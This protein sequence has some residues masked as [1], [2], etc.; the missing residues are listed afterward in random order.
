M[1]R[2]EFF[3]PYQDLNGAQRSGYIDIEVPNYIRQNLTDKFDLRYYQ[4]EAI[5]Y[6]EEYLN[7]NSYSSTPHHL[8][9]Q[10]AT[11]SGKTLIL[12][13]NIL[14]LYK[15]G[16][17]NFIFFVDSKDIIQKTQENLL[18]KSSN[19]YLFNK[20]INI[21]SQDIRVNQVSNF[22][23]I[24]S[25]S[26]NIYLTTVQG[27][28]TQ[29][30]NPSENSLTFE[31]FQNKETVLLA[32][33]AHHL[34][35]ETKSESQ[36]KKSEKEN[37]NR[38]ETTIKKLLHTNENNI[39][40]EYTATANL[41]EPSI[42]DKYEDK[43]LYQ[44]PLRQ[45]RKD[46]Y[47]KEVNVLDADLD[48]MDRALYSAIL[49]QYRLKI[50]EDAGIDSFK[51]VILMKSKTISLSNQNKS[52][53]IS[54]INTI[55]AERIKSLRGKLSGESGVLTQAFNYFE[56]KNISY[57]NLADEIQFAF[58]EEK[59]LEINSRTDDNIEEKEYL[60]NTL[61]DR[62]N[63]I[64]VIFSV[65]K[66]TEGWDVLNLF[67]IVR[68]DG[69]TGP[70]TTVREAQLIGRGAR[71]YPFKI[72]STQ[73]KYKRKFDDDIK[74][75]YRALEELYYHSEH[76]PEYISD[77]KTELI[78]Q[79][80]KPEE[81]EQEEVD[82]RVKDNFKESRFW[83]TGRLFVN[84]KIDKL[85]F[86]IESIKQLELSEYKYEIR[87][88]F[89]TEDSLF[90]V[91]EASLSPE[92]ITKRFELSQFNQN[93]IYKAIHRNS[94][95]TYTNLNTYFDSLDS[96]DTF[97]NSDE[98]L[99]KINVD[100]LAP[101]ELF[102]SGLSQTHKVNIVQSVLDTLEDDIRGGVTESE[103][104]TE[105]YAEPISEVVKNKTRN[106][107]LNPESNDGEGIPISETT[108]SELR[109]DISS[110]D[111]YVYEE[112]YGTDEE[113]YFVNF[114][115]SAMKSL[116][117]QFESVYLLRNEG[118]FQLHRFEDGKT[119][120][121]DFVLFVKKESSNSPEILQLFLE[122][123]GDFLREN[124][125]WKQEFLMEIESIYDISRENLYEDENIR[126]VGLPFYTEE[127]KSEFS[128]S[129]SDALGVD[130]L[131]QSHH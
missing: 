16:Y 90:N 49:S 29:L 27:L 81:G 17:R 77:L 76:N 117:S 26:I 39:L 58:S 73:D 63:N 105:F 78:Q 80:I 102:D 95:Y 43:L 19:K 112:M 7:N 22:S 130:N 38:W 109:M 4:E 64:R 21:N 28:H 125:E 42:R 48:K 8:L 113:K 59:I 84:K 20:T 123:K 15:R 94:F 93:V 41:G 23:T 108:N 1:S 128:E 24:Q 85:E 69:G 110:K 118:L 89:I 86:N 14:E 87:T 92:T 100:V 45:Y 46:K 129:L 99:N 121:P 44:Y 34:D 72:D 50:A 91:E 36:R 82:L 32:D 122:P 119:M 25:S 35:A 83:D 5:T 53:F 103:G 68:L 106:I 10:M 56:D 79:G 2:N 60:V 66:L 30:N 71:Y 31:E 61:E 6:F 131:Y 55:D 75:K 3:G 70:K 98:Y 54:E 18:N 96:L 12:A 57:S 101:Q 114:I 67:D 126:L 120:E 9:Y 111:W 47:S 74:H 88:G 127:M 40:I 97:V 62:D 65:Q 13:A 11:G 51:P 107:H 104:T 115:N 124:D 116:N 33:E 37:L 52:D